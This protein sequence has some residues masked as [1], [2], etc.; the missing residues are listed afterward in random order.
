MDQ[1]ARGSKALDGG[2]YDEA[3]KEFTAAIAI[4][5]TSP[6]YHIKR[7]TAYQRISPPNLDAALHDAEKGVLLAIERQKRETVTQAQFRRAIVLFRMERYGDSR[8]LF[9][10]VR[11]RNPKENL[12]LWDKQLENKLQA[13]SGD[14]PKLSVTVP[15]IPDVKKRS[16]DSPQL[17]DAKELGSGSK[18]AAPAPMI[19]T[20]AR[21]IRTEWYQSSNTVYLTLLAKGVP[22]DEITVEFKSDAVGVYLLTI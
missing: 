2:R 12:S 5:P 15:E 4:H 13:L 18:P 20:P 6:D 8:F 1:A 17:K 7:S 16:E 11:Q 10:I 14:D 3:I 19:R 21:Q 22:K 9:D